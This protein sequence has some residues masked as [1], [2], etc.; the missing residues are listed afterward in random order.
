[1]DNITFPTSV[2]QAGLLTLGTT[3]VRLAS[4]LDIPASALTVTVRAVHTNA[5]VILVGKDGSEPRR[6]RLDE[7]ADIPY[8]DLTQYSISA[9]SEEDA[10]V[11]TFTRPMTDSR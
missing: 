7:S 6:L 9:D 11:V 5:D 4:L 2:H 3:P 1:M 8:A 10:V